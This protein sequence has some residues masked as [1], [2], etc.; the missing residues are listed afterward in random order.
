MLENRRMS[1]IE[2]SLLQ[3]P[4]LDLMGRDLD[5]IDHQ[6]GIHMSNVFDEVLRLFFQILSQRLDEAMSMGYPEQGISLNLLFRR[7]FIIT[8]RGWYES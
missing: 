2:C 3:T 8:Y 7:I 5:L 1:L 6:F 4:A